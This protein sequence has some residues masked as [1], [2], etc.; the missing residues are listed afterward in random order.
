MSTG[1][2]RSAPGPESRSPG[3][4]PAVAWSV[5]LHVLSLPWLIAS[6]IALALVVSALGIELGGSEDRALQALLFTGFLVLT[7]APLAASAVIGLRAWR[8]RR[9]RGG[10]VAGAMSIVVGVLVLLVSG[11][12]LLAGAGG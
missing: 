6:L 2:A 9:R 3:H 10:L 11:T 1:K 8:R 5:T 7:L 12:I 4:D